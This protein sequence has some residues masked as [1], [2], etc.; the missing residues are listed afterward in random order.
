MNAVHVWKYRFT[1][2]CMN[3]LHDQ[4]YNAKAP[5]YAT[6]L[7]LDRKLRAFP[8]PS[9]LQIAGFG[10]AE[11]RA[12]GS[13]ESIALMLQRHLVLSLREASTSSLFLS[14]FYFLTTL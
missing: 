12:A 11:P 2:D 14:N 7:Q 13:S 5:T 8:V 1:S 10:S 3:A 9:M 6:V 4:A